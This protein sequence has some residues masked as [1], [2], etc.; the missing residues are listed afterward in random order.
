M[1]L[2]ELLEEVESYKPQYE[3]L[4]NL[5]KMI[6]NEVI[7]NN[8]HC[9]HTMESLHVGWEELHSCKYGSSPDGVGKTPY[10]VH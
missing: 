6:Q 5:N 9:K 4:E 1:P 3:E 7:F 10:F 8:P 2:A